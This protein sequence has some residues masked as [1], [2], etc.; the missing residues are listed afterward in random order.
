MDERFRFFSKHTDILNPHLLALGLRMAGKGIEAGIPF[1]VTELFDSLNIRL[2]TKGNISVLDQNPPNGILF[3]GDHQQK[4]EYFPLLALCGQ[5]K[6]NDIYFMGLPPFFSN[7]TTFAFLIDP[8]HTGHVLPVLHR[9]FGYDPNDWYSRLR[10]TVSTKLFEDGSFLDRQRKNMNENSLKT[11]GLLLNKKHVVSIFPTGDPN[12]P[13]DA[14]WQNGVGTIVN[15]VD[16][17]T[18]NVY[19]IP[20]KIEPGMV[21][22]FKRAQKQYMSGIPPDP[23]GITIQVGAPV[24]INDIRQKTAGQTTE[25]IQKY[26]LQELS[27]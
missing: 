5:H 20:Y 17:T 9:H 8:L 15:F 14:R 23:Q 1:S 7:A 25:A 6:R 22:V 2:S 12:K 18:Q 19:V 3:V 24:S 26:Y 11:A 16:S 13:M 21:H 10:S 27:L 4:Y